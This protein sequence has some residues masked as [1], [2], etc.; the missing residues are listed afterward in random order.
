MTPQYILQKA[1]C[2]MPFKGWPAQEGYVREYAPERLAWEDEWTE[3]GDCGKLV[4]TSGDCYSWQ[5]HYAILGDC[6]LICLDCLEGE[7]ESYLEGLED[8][9][10]T[11]CMRR[12]DPSES[13]I[14]GSSDDPRKILGGLHLAGRRARNIPAFRI[15]PILFQIRDLAQDRGRR[16]T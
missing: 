5:P 8:N 16:R 11:C 10:S 1:I 4:R 3:C 9:P 13:G 15:Q 6:D 2:R 7:A 12:I 14:C